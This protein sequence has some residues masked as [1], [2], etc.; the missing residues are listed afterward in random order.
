MI[1]KE[2]NRSAQRERFPFSTPVPKWTCI[3]SNRDFRGKKSPASRQNHDM[4]SRPFRE[5]PILVTVLQRPTNCPSPQP[6]RGPKPFRTLRR[7]AKLLALAEIRIHIPR[8]SGP[9]VICTAKNSE[10]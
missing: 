7:I 8:L 6:N 10:D 9:N 2:A 5:N 4:V 1:V 3:K